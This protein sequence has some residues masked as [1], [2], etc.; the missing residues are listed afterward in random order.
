MLASTSNA[1]AAF[2]SATGN[3]NGQGTI[4]LGGGGSLDQSV[5][6]EYDGLGT[7]SV[8][9]EVDSNATYLFSERILNGTG[10]PWTGF[11]W[12]LTGET[13][14]VVTLSLSGLSDEF[15]NV[16]TISSTELEANGGVVGNGENFVGD[17]RVRVSG[18]SS[19]GIFTLTQS[20]LVPSSVPEPGVLALFGLGLAGLGL[21]RRRRT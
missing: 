17:I 19:G 1:S 14:G 3:D 9:F 11:N 10:T 4:I 8:D 21:A 16:D 7:M 12:V 18:S 20:P 6:K 2:V 13:D 5:R 15:T